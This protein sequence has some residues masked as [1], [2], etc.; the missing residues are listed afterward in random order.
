M[1]LSHPQAP[2]DIYTFT[3]LHFYTFTLL[4]FYTFTLLH[5]YTVTLLLVQG[6]QKQR[7]V[8]LQLLFG[9][10]VVPIC[11]WNGT[12]GAQK[13]RTVPVQLPSAAFLAPAP[14]ILLA[15]TR[16]ASK[17]VKV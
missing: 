11:L 9:V 8:P 6:A 1:G 17:S 5:F 2:P 10:L 15:S 7:T 3:L 12:Q 13:R 14:D 16:E 4:H